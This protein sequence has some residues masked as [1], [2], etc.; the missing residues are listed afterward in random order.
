MPVWNVGF[1]VAGKFL[2]S[3][4][5][6]SAEAAREKAFTS[7]LAAVRRAS[8]DGIRLSLDPEPGVAKSALAVEIAMGKVGLPRLDWG[9]VDTLLDIVESEF[10]QAL[11]KDALA[12]IRAAVTT[13]MRYPED[14]TFNK[15]LVMHR[16]QM[17][18]RRS[19]RL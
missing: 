19:K 17:Q 15:A 9:A 18:E 4:Q 7:F 10:S 14:S 11:E 12:I 5:A 3:T 13:A 1:S 16:Q 2:A 6:V 8:Q